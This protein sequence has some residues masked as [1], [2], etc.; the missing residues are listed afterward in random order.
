MTAAGGRGLEIGIG[1]RYRDV[2]SQRWPVIVAPQSEELLSS[3][4]HRLAIANGVAPRDFARVLGSASRPGSGPGSGLWSAALDLRLPAP[5]AACLLTHT[6]V[7][8]QKLAAMSLTRSAWRP[9]L[10]PLRSRVRRSR[11]TWLQ[12]CSCCLAEDA[13]SYFRRRWRLATWISCPDHGCGLRDRCRSCGS[14]IAASDQPDLVPQHLCVRCGF[15]LRRAPKVAVST[16]A[17]RL[18]RCIDDICRLE[19][20]TGR[21]TGNQGGSPLFKCLQRLPAIAG[22]APTS[23][24][25]GLSASARRRCF[26]QLAHTPCT[27]L[28]A[29][30][31]GVVVH[32][33]RLILAAGG[34]GALMGQL[35]KALERGGHL[36][37]SPPRSAPKAD[38][39]AL[40]A[41]YLDIRERAPRP[42]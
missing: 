8:R 16:A 27:W 30:D 25:S 19:A 10:L 9:L 34:T 26:E 35:A 2:V 28:T 31:D 6:G 4:L 21:L 37:A 36:Q 11:S 39:P 40:L 22:L 17:R 14:G 18:E 20:V 38:L 41:A 13:Q 29:G 23:T 15:D 5:V 7:S 33:R 3:W 24:L 12:Y 32:W 1:P 42:R